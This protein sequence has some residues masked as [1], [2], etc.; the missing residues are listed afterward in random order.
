MTDDLISQETMLDTGVCIRT[1]VTQKRPVAAHLLDP[2]QIDLGEHQ[3]LVLGGFGDHHPERVADERVS[4]EFDPP[5]LPPPPPPPPAPP[6]PPPAPPRAPP[7]HPR[8]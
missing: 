7:A 2:C 8:P 3:R 1:A 6:E 5:P 4:P